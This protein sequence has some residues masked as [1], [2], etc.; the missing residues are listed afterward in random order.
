MT[1]ERGRIDRTTLVSAALQGNPLGDPHERPIWVYL[2]PG[3]DDGDL[4]YPCIYVIQ[5]FTGQLAMW[6]NRAPWRPTY[7][8]AVDDLF[9]SGRAP[10]CIVVFV[11][12]WTRLGGSQYVDSPGTGRYHTY[13][14]DDVVAWVDRRYRTLDDPRHRGISGKSS[15]GY[16]AMITPMLRPDVFG[17]L[18]TH[19]GDA[20][21]EVSYLPDFPAAAR[22]LR[23]HWDGSYQAYLRDFRSRPAWTHPDDSLLVELWAVAACFSTDPDGTVR[24]PFDP[25]TGRVDDAVW[26]RWLDR[27]P[28]RMAPLHADA[29]RG[30]RAV[31]V[32][33]GTSDEWYLDLAATA[34][35]EQLVALEIDDHHFELSEDTHRS[36][37]HRYP[38]ALQYL[39][40]RLSAP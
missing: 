21:F 35:H 3:Y 18:A 5:G 20:L 25:A 34:F 29:L 6:D 14:C 27:D 33:A 12:A 40:E 7:P 31:W 23:D 32:G 19:A 8:E 30:L 2:P 36:I 39:A 26:S 37:A 28:V 22:T 24:L 4:R 13:L 15:G 16:G 17:G 9:S 10:P 1:A 38:A 11:D